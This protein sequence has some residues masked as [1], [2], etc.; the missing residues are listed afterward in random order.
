MSFAANGI[1]V[2]RVSNHDKAGSW[3]CGGVRCIDLAHFLLAL[4][5]IKIEWREKHTLTTI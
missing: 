1:C 5:L 3:P 4:R 2:G